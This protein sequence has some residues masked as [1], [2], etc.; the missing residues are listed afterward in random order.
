[1]RRILDNPSLVVG[2]TI[3]ATIVLIAV[4]APIL[5]SYSIEQMDMANR[6]SGPTAAHWLG[7]DNFGRDLWARM[8]HGA[9][10]S[11][12]IALI[13]IAAAVVIGT[14]IGLI[15]GYFGGI[16]DLVVMRIVDIFLG[17]PPLILALAL[18]AALG[19]GVLNLS[20][21]LIAVFWTEYARVVRAVTLSLREYDYVDAA[22]A[23][24]ASD[25]RI[26]LREILPN[27]IGPVTVLATLGLGTAIVAESGLSFLGFGVQPPTPTWGWT[28]AYGTR[29]LRSDPW[30]STVA[31]LA[32]MI[33]VLGFNLLGDGLRDH[34]DPRGVVRRARAGKA[35][36]GT[37]GPTKR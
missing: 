14:T 25:A 5:S 18:V 30:L 36:D 22:R 11:V 21:A 27:T 15:A 34:L 33:T 2:G 7:T 24:G 13:S 28:L 12:A 32:I 6:L 9:R 35:P 20:A 3:V 4:F 8:A 29:Y 16:V 37:A 26:L 31:G 10:V 23:I 19:P 17:F 1:M